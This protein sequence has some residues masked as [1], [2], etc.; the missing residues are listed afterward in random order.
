MPFGSS[1]VENLTYGDGFARPYSRQVLQGPGAT[2][3]D[4][5]SYTYDLVGRLASTSMPCAVSFAQTCS[6]PQTT[7]TYDA[8]NRPLVTTDAG[9]GTVTKSYTKNDVLVVVGPN[10]V[11]EHTKQKQYEYNGLGQLTSVCEVT[12]ASGSGACGQNASPFFFDSC[13]TAANRDNFPSLTPA[14]YFR[15]AFPASKVKIVRGLHHGVRAASRAKTH[16]RC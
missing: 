7:Q 6:T 14:L 5:V 13:W 10:P 12:S 9:G 8:L 16:R 4:T 2:T 15:A 11:G 3:L 1:I